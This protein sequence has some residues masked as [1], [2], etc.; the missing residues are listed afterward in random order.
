MNEILKFWLGLRICLLAT[1][2]SLIIGLIFCPD[3]IMFILVSAGIISA[4]V[5]Y[6]SVRKRLKEK[7]IIK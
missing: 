6:L 5:W 1:T 4:L 7:G 3:W 2:V